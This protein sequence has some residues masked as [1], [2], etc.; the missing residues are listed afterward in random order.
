MAKFIPTIDR[1]DDLAPPFGIT[2]P[3][4]EGSI[5]ESLYTLLSRD[6][7]LEGYVGS[8]IYPLA[9]PQGASMP[10]ITYQQVGGVRDEVMTGPSGL[11]K[12]GFQIN[13]WAE[14]YAETRV[15][16]NAVRKVL[17][18]YG[19]IGKVTI[20]ASF[21]VGEGDMI[22]TAPGTDVLKRYGKCLDFTIW[23]I[24]RID[25]SAPA[26]GRPVSK[27][28]SP[29]G[30]NDGWVSAANSAQA[31]DDNMALSAQTGEIAAEGNSGWLEMTHAAIYCDRIRVW[32]ASSEYITVSV[33]V[34]YNSGWHTVTVE[35]IDTW[36][37]GSL[38]GIYGVTKMR[39][40][41]TN[42]DE[43]EVNNFYLTEVDFGVAFNYI[44]QALYTLMSN[45]S[46]LGGYV[47]TRIYPSIV[48][49]GAAM[50]A[51]TYQQISGMRDDVMT[52]PTGLV[53]SRFQINCWAETYKETRIL[54]NAVENVFD[55]FDGTANNVVI[56]CI[57]L[58]DEG[59]MPQISPGADVLKRYGKRLDFIVWFKE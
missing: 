25:G 24:N 40:K 9:V 16:S 6:T 56:Q 33:Q 29:T 22:E 37:V 26:F 50:P 44:E 42:R 32:I 18:G 45:D 58:V 39:V 55:G 2:A 47:S 12:S 13:C 27:W 8:R 30:D 4:D 52:G 1:I 48:P 3:V 38:G 23:F 35:A 57:H 53:E 15:I 10:A 54:S 46:T 51:I 28:V 5:E 59:D 41:L 11:I 19:R 21:C 36:S 49:Q 17:D 20:R 14:T 34:Y 31:W 43:E 7:T